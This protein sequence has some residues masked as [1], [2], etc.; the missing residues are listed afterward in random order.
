VGSHFAREDSAGSV[1]L[2]RILLH[3][4]HGFPLP[5]TGSFLPLYLRLREQTSVSLPY[6]L[7]SNAIDRPL[8]P[9]L[10][11]IAAHVSRSS[12]FLW[13]DPMDHLSR[14]VLSFRLDIAMRMS[15]SGRVYAI[16]Q[17][18]RDWMRHTQ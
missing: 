11:R 3:G 10:M 18:S 13:A 12:Q 2:T 5:Y 8:A 15:S 16:V 7:A 6:N 14:S 1:S 4:M 9:E 17:G